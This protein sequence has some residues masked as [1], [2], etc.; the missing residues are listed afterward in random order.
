M[1]SAPVAVARRRYVDNSGYAAAVRRLVRAYGQRV[2]DGTLEDLAE[3]LQ[4]HA[5]VD[6]AAQ[7]AVDRLREAGYTWEELGAVTGHTKQAAI[8]KWLRRPVQAPR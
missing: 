7:S 6:R 5:D 1:T 3:L 8:K 2:A 4:L